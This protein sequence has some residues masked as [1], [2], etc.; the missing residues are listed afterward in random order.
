MDD[1]NYRFEKIDTRVSKPPIQIPGSTLK[2]IAIICMFIDHIGAAILERYIEAHK[3][4]GEDNPNLDPAIIVD[5]ILRLIGRISFPI[6]IFLIVEGYKHTKNR[7]KYLQRL[8]LFALISEL[9]FDMAFHLTSS[10]IKS[11]KITTFEHQNIFFTLALGLV[12]MVLIDMVKQLEYGEKMTKFLN[13]LFLVGFTIIGF[14]LKVDY[15]GV[16]VLA[17]LLMYLFSDK[18]YK[19]ILLS[20]VALI[21]GGGIFEA[22]ALLAVI[23]ISKYNGERGINIKYFFYAFYPAHLLVFALIDFIM[24]I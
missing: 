23:P 10:D 16:G 4:Q 19:A 11:G 17:I 1:Q 7:W 14:M 22:A 5:A 15:A 2:I 9:P 24:G 3:I 20:C 18:G 12:G 6:F 8:L 13:V 21:I